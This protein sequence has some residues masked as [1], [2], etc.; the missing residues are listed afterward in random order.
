MRNEVTLHSMLV[1]VSLCG[2][3][4]GLAEALEIPEYL[5]KSIEDD[6]LK[7]PGINMAGVLLYYRY[8][9]DAPYFN[10]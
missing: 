6:Y 1:V 10:F 7:V 4:Y 3:C 5:H 9:S 8:S 2:C